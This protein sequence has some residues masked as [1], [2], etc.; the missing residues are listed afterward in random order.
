M[1]QP[2]N[3]GSAEGI[4]GVQAVKKAG[5]TVQNSKH[6]HI[7]EVQRCGRHLPKGQTK[8]ESKAGNFLKGEIY[9]SGNFNSVAHLPGKA[10]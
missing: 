10:A 2:G 6:K 5:R 3:Q 4:L 9:S 7:E 8:R 1:F